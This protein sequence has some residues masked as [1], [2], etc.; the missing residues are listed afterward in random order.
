MS[1]LELKIPPLALVIVV[2]AAMALLARWLPV[3]GFTVPARHFVVAALA[4][5]GAAVALLGVRAFVRART[6][7]DP[8]LPQESSRLVS[9]GVYRL[10]RNPM[11]LGFA[12]L[13]AAWGLWLANA[14]ALLGVPAFVRYLNRY[15]IGP[16]ERALERR[17]GVDFERYRAQ[18]RRWL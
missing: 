13:L 7:V 11:Y 4:L 14:A 10:S 16:E 2:A 6:T 3:L 17:F 15:Q 5:P 9:S 8:R 18:V 1:S 12:L